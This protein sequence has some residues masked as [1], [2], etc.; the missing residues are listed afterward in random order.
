MGIS[1]KSGIV[2]WL[3]YIVNY[4]T[5]TKKICILVRGCIKDGWMTDQKNCQ[6]TTRL[7]EI[8]NR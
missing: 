5:T 3:T 7:V 4:T 1:S 2:K 8:A 6:D